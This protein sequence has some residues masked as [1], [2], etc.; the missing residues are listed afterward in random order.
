MGNE[1]RNDIRWL[2]QINYKCQ[3]D[4]KQ[5]GSSKNN[6]TPDSARRFLFPGGKKNN[7]KEKKKKVCSIIRLYFCVNHY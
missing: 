3:T 1:G 4:E 2:L 6:S 7:P 5:F